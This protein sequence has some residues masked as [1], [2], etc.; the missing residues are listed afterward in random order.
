M[1]LKDQAEFLARALE[2]GLKSVLEVIAWADENITQLETPP[3]WLLE[4]SLMG[5]AKAQ[6]VVNALRESDGI[7]NEAKVVRGYFGEL[8]S[9]IR[10]NV[11]S[12][13][14]CCRFLYRINGRFTDSQ[15]LE[16][17]KLDDRYDWL[18]DEDMVCSETREDIDKDLTAL[19]ERESSLFP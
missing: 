14:E 10:T 3:H 5:K 4:L 6:D 8:L 17:Q 19:L 9:R 18:M 7:A 11:W 12:A 15:S 1:S 13:E 16:I 2:G